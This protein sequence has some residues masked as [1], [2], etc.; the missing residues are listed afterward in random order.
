MK[1]HIDDYIYLYICVI[2]KNHNAKYNLTGFICNL[3]EFFWKLEISNESGRVE[4]G[5]V[6][7]FQL[8]YYLCGFLLHISGNMCIYL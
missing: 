7:I 8:E 5:N 2:E 4:F 1:W 6:I 3:Q